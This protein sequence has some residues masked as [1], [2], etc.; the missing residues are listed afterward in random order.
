M[1]KSRIYPPLFRGNNFHK[2][3]TLLEKFKE[4]RLFFMN[5]VLYVYFQP[6]SQVLT[7]LKN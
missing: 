3:S 1:Q 7:G 6:V 2:E 4:T 5:T